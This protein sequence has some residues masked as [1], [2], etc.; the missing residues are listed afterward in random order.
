MAMAMAAMAIEREESKNHGRKCRVGAPE[1]TPLDHL[2]D[3]IAARRERPQLFTRNH[4]ATSLCS[5]LRRLKAS[6]IRIDETTLL[7]SIATV[8]PPGTIFRHS[9]SQLNMTE[10][11]DQPK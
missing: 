6:S 9:I 8:R 4:S 10:M 3:W 5:C 11:F 1:D 7:S 2:V